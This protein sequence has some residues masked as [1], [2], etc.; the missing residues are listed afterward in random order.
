[1]PSSWR[2]Q[3]AF[4]AVYALSLVLIF[5]F[6]LNFIVMYD[7]DPEQEYLKE[8]FLGLYTKFEYNESWGTDFDPTA[9]KEL[10]VLLFWAATTGLA[11]LVRN[12]IYKLSNRQ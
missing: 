6:I 9:P 3:L 10:F 2:Q 4:A 7:P 12:R 11:Y 1:M 8:G 5:G